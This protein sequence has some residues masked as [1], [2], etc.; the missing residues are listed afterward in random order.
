MTIL[1]S[2]A[3]PFYLENLTSYFEKKPLAKAFISTGTLAI[4][5]VQFTFNCLGHSDIAKQQ[6]ADTI[7]LVSFIFN[8]FSVMMKL[9]ALSQ[10]TFFSVAPFYSHF[11]SSAITSLTAVG[12]VLVVAFIGYKTITLLNHALASAKTTQA[13]AP[14]VKVSTKHPETDRIHQT[15]LF[16][17]VALTTLNAIADRSLPQIASVALSFLHVGNILEIAKRKWVLL[18]K[19]IGD[20]KLS[21]YALFVL[22][23]NKKGG[24]CSVCIDTFTDQNPAYHFC[25][26]HSLCKGDLISSI[27]YGLGKTTSEYFNTKTIKTDRLGNVTDYSYKVFLIEDNLP[28]CPECRRPQAQKTLEARVNTLLGWEE[29]TVSIL[30]REQYEATLSTYQRRRRQELSL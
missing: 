8:S 6:I 22:N 21:Y 3:T 15:I 1:L 2:A 9:H 17:N 30:P 10:K 25:E 20:L 7:D 11:S 13:I 24:E 28:S 14:E 27:S 4:G 29:A 5:S 12:T 19:T 16:G 18:E 26:Y 23:K